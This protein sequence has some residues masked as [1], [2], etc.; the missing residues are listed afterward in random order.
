MDQMLVSSWTPNSYIAALT[1][2]VTICGDGAFKEVIKVK[3]DQ[4]GAQAQ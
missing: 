1:S 2:G 4:S 3:W